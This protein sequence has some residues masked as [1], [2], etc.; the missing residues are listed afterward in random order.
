MHLALYQLYSG[1]EF[2][3]PVLII[4]SEVF[5]L[6]FSPNVQIFLIMCAVSL[7]W[8]FSTVS[9]SC[10]MIQ[11]FYKRRQ[12][13][14][15]KKC[16]SSKTFLQYCTSSRCKQCKNPG[17][18]CKVLSKICVSY[19]ANIN[20]KKYIHFEQICFMHTCHWPL[21]NCRNIVYMCV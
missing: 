10:V 6:V 13:L 16:G 7:Q 3:M 19:S 18:F 20:V 21:K 1:H 12:I 2:L 4:M 5:Y 11:S 9:A 8:L 15:I 17:G 14:T